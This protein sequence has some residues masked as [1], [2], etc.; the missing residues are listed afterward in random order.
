MLKKSSKI[1]NLQRISFFLL[2]VGSFCSFVYI[3]QL[4]TSEILIKREVS[5]LF[6]VGLTALHD[7]YKGEYQTALTGP[8]KGVS[9]FKDT[10]T[11]DFSDLD[12]YSLKLISYKNT[13][14]VESSKSFFYQNYGEGKL[15]LLNNQYK[16]NSFITKP[17]FIGLV[18]LR[19]WVNSQWRHGD[20]MRMKFHN[21]NAIEVLN[22]AE[23][24]EKFLCGEYS[25]TYVQ[26]VLAIGGQAR[27]ILLTGRDNS[28]HAVAEVWSNQF[29]KWITM[30]VDFNLHYSRN[31]VPQNSLE[32]HKA[33]VNNH[34]ENIEVVQGK[35]V[36]TWLNEKTFPAK[37][38]K[39]YQNFAIRMRNDFFNYYPKWHFKGN[40]YVNML[41]WVDDFSRGRFEFA[42]STG[43]EDDLYWNLNHSYLK[44]NNIIQKDSD[45]TLGI[46]INLLSQ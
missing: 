33:L 42:Y 27:V 9:V 7:P 14:L 44:L 45:L 29:E 22:L 16:L 20:T 11:Y 10:E 35:T 19:E 34:T 36:P 23:N 26:S 2:I 25:Y 31:E 13:P 6:Y 32:L 3:G 41:E 4:P 5:R 12:K 30:D 38:L 1:F 17:D 39:K 37:G 40:T 21:F 28:G 8:A 15:A 43:K 24:G 18:G 46:S